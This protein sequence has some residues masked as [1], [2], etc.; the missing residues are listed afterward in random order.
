MF[1]SLFVFLFSLVTVAFGHSPRHHVGEV[2]V[3]AEVPA[4]GFPEDAV[5]H[6]HQLFVSQPA[7]FGTAGSGPSPIRVYDTTTTPYT[8]EDTIY[9]AGELLEFE[10][11][12]TGEAIDSE[13]RLIVL[14]NQLGILRFSKV[15]QSWQQENL[16]G[17]FPVFGYPYFSI[18]NGVVILTDDSF[19]VSDSVQNLIWSVPANGGVPSLWFQ[20]AAI[21]FGGQMGLNALKMSPTHDFVY[22]ADTERNR[23]LRLPLTGM[24]PPTPAD[25]VIVYTFDQGSSPDGL[26][27]DE[28]GDLWVVLAEADAVVKLDMGCGG[29]MEIS[30]WIEDPLFANPSNLYFIGG[31]KAVLVNHALLGGVPYLFEIYLGENGDELPY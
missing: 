10:H 28:R 29:S 19:L 1:H 13:G 16:S 12:L 6:G 2:T 5:L 17:P 27:F 30:L 8:L 22:F 31:R 26:A 24:S 9:V 11:S 7:N 4:P 14:S 21:S 18:P 25:L 23:I 3:M 20:D 15:G